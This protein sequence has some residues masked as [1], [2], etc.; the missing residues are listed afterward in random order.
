VQ[1]ELGGLTKPGRHRQKLASWCLQLNDLQIRLW[2]QVAEQQ[3]NRLV[4]LRQMLPCQWLFVLLN[5]KH[6]AAAAHC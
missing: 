5:H 4:R 6:Q 3:S 2:R 1:I